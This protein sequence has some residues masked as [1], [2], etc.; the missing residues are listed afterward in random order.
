MEVPPPDFKSSPPPLPGRGASK[1]AKTKKPF[2]KAFASGGVLYAAI[3]V[4][5][6]LSGAQNIVYRATYS[7]M[8]CLV[9]TVATAIWCCKDKQVWSW[10][11]IIGTVIGIYGAV[12]FIQMQGSAQK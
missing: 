5:I 3:V 11:R 1:L 12:F 8:S 6:L 10:G 9:A 7:F 2:L 4:S